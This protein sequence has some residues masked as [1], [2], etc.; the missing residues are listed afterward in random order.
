VVSHKIKVLA[1]FIVLPELLSLEERSIVFSCV[2]RQKSKGTECMKSLSR[3]LNKSQE[4]SL[5]GLITSE[6][7]IIYYCHIGNI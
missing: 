3:A 2:G 1:V 6:G 4:R 5:H 7:L